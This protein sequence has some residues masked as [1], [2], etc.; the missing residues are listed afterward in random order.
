[1]LLPGM[2]FGQSEQIYL[3]NEDGVRAADVLPSRLQSFTASFPLQPLDLQSGTIAGANHAFLGEFNPVR[4][5]RREYR[6]GHRKFSVEFLEMGQPSRAFGLYTFLSWPSSGRPS[7]E[8]FTITDH[9]D[10]FVV[11][12]TAM[13]LSGS[14]KALP[15]EAKELSGAVL[16]RVR[17]TLQ[18]FKNEMSE[19]PTVFKD[20]PSEGLIPG[21]SRLIFG[22]VGL[23][24]EIAYAGASSIRFDAGSKIALGRYKDGEGETT[25]ALIEYQTPQLAS[26]G[27]SRLQ[28]INAGIAQDGERPVLKREGNYLVAAFGFRDRSRA[29]VLADR[30]RYSYTVKYLATPP[31]P[32]F[33]SAK[34]QREA[35]RLLVGIFWLV[36]NVTCAAVLLGVAYG[37]S[38]FVRRYRRSRDSFVDTSA[39]LRLNL[40]RLLP[41]APA[42]GAS[43]LLEKGE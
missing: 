40:D 21:S 2:S 12:V 25:L 41:P 22:P 13:N 26:E 29:K 37:I 24:H 38:L 42:D 32:Y 43:R 27:F 35:Y 10:R 36:V 3:L 39:M 7:D 34:Y 20:L 28:Q 31:P 9:A 17:E 18:S 11:R 15:N 30:V 23:T 5:S 6:R 16:R 1:M 14:S 4:A 8:D 19:P 33:D